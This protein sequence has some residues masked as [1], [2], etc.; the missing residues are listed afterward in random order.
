M[1]PLPIYSHLL[2]HEGGAVV[3]G[4]GLHVGRGV[5]VARGQRFG[6]GTGGLPAGV[7]GPPQR[8]LQRGSLRKRLKRWH[9]LWGSQRVKIYFNILNKTNNRGKKKHESFISFDW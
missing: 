5:R 4:P 9:S 8:E 2:T 7:A 3:A 1:Y 6:H